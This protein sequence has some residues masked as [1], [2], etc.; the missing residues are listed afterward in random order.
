MLPLSKRTKNRKQEAVE[1]PRCYDLAQM[2]GKS[3]VGASDM[4]QRVVKKTGVVVV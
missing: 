3:W 2:R 1:K 4:G